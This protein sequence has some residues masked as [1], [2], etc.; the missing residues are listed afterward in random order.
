VRAQRYELT[1]AGEGR[2]I[3][4]EDW[5]DLV[6]CGVELEMNAYLVRKWT[7]GLK[8]CPCCG[9]K[10]D[11]RRV[12]ASQ[13]DWSTWLDFGL[14]ALN[15]RNADGQ[16]VLGAISNFELQKS[17]T[18]T[19][20]TAASARYTLRVK[21][22]PPRVATARKSLNIHRYLRLRL[23]GALTRSHPH[24]FQLIRSFRHP[25]SNSMDGPITPHL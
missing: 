18:P 15:P 9:R 25:Q 1:K 12:I 2:P 14:R 24:T 13:G 7:I 16:I 8:A 19:R 6:R 11:L 22:S 4:Q 17:S 20:T 21:M 3:V 10:F 5:E 23:S